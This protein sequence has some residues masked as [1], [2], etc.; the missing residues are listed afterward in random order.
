MAAGEI[1][2]FPLF[3]FSLI[4]HLTPAICSTPHSRVRPTSEEP[5]ALIKII[6][7]QGILRL[8][9]ALQMV[10]LLSYL[11]GDSIQAKPTLTNR[12]S[13][14]SKSSTLA[15]GVCHE[16]AKNKL[17]LHTHRLFGRLTRATTTEVIFK[18]FKSNIIVLLH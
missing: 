14:A 13:M 7:R 3:Y 18:I 10:P 6:Q 1:H 2:R 8:V 12:N 9:C 15:F 5:F 11:Q 17:V 16:K 4:C